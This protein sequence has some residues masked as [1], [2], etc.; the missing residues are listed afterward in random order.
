[1]ELEKLNAIID[2]VAKDKGISKDILIEAL[3]A[4]MLTAARKVY[5]LERDIEAHWNDETG[6]VEIFEFRTVVDKIED[7]ATEIIHEEALNEDPECQV[8]DSLGFKREKADLGRI[9]AQTA[10]QVII[11]RVR[12]A[13]RENVFDEY[14]DRADR[15]SV[16]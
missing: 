9:A 14:A 11:Q 12:E 3:E 13:E 4:A 16:V 6:D 2:Q 5:G 10:K 7:A 8:G 15:K 1:M